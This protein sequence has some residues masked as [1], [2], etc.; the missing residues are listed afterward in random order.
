MIT[1]MI[2]ILIYVIF[3]IPV[4]L[5]LIPI[6]LQTPIFNN[7]KLLNIHHSVGL[8]K[9]KQDNIYK[10]MYVVD[11]SPNIPI[12]NPHNI[13]KLLL[14]NYVN[15]K[16]RVFYFD[17]MNHDYLVDNFNHIVNI[18][19]NRIIITE[20][21]C[22]CNS[23]FHYD[24]PKY[25]KTGFAKQD[26]VL[27]GENAMFNKAE[28]H[29]LLQELHMILESTNNWDLDFQLYNHN[30]QHFSKYFIRRANNLF[31]D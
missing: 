8:Y 29:V 11:F 9:N 24:I 2:L 3:F 20:N 28:L 7:N 1:Y 18:S 4:S 14:G 17:T 22:D 5:S 6:I 26:L 16:I 31:M 13:G 30:C 10:H 19:T 12:D 25:C 27:N 15:G 23:E 21:L